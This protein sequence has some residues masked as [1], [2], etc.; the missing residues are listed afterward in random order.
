[1]LTAKI[2]DGDK[3]MGLTIGADDYIT[4]TTKIFSFIVYTPFYPFIKWFYCALG[5]QPHITDF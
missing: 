1:M 3:I 2:D 4:N 5:Y